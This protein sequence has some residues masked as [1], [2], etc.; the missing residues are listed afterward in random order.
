MDPKAWGCASEE[1]YRA[2]QRLLTGRMNTVSKN[3]CSVERNLTRENVQLAWKVYLRSVLALILSFFLYLSLTFLFSAFGTSSIG[4]EV[5]ELGEDGQYHVVSVHYFSDETTAATQEDTTAAEATQSTAANET[6]A[7]DDEQGTEAAGEDTAAST[8]GPTQ[9]TQ[10]LR[11]ELSPG[12]ELFCDVLSSVLMILILVSV[13]YTVLSKE[14]D[15]DSNA[16]QFG[17]IQYDRFRGIRVGL[18]AAV[19]SILSYLFLIVSKLTGL[20]PQY[21]S[22]FRLSNMPFLPL[23]N[24]FVSSTVASSADVPWSA[25]LVM[26]V[27]VVVVPLSCAAGYYMGYRHISLSE[28]LVYQKKKKS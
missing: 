18:L 16:V 15:R 20:V 28:N 8:A 6:E 12:V 21:V 22:F 2:A 26:A 24:H 3:D 14:G 19:P 25:I 9:V 11:S 23:F 27:T 10:Y 5:M 4:Y 1:V 17:H 13:T 7:A